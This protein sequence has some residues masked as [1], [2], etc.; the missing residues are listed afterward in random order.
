MVLVKPFLVALCFIFCTYAGSSYSD[1]T[2]KELEDTPSV[3]VLE[4]H[5]DTPKIETKFPGNGYDPNSPKGGVLKFGLVKT[6]F[7]T[8][9]PFIQKDCAPGIGP[10]NSLVFEALM[11][12]DP[13]APFKLHI[14]IAKSVKL[15]RDRSWMEVTLNEDARFNDGSRITANDVIATFNTLAAEGSPSR[16]AFSKKIKT[17]KAIDN[18]KILFIF[19]KTPDSTDKDPKYDLEAPLVTAM[20]PVLS[21][22]DIKSFSFSERGMRPFLGSG[23]YKISKIDPGKSVTFVRN[24]SYWG[25]GKLECIKG[26]YNADT[27]VLKVFYDPSTLFSAFLSG[28][29]HSFQEETA[30]KWNSLQNHPYV[31][32]GKIVLRQVNRNDTVGMTGFAMNTGV[33]PFNDIRFRRAIAGFFDVS[34]LINLLGGDHKPITSFFHGTEFAAKT[35]PDTRETE[36]LKKLSCKN[37]S[38]YELLSRGNKVETKPGDKIGAL[39]Q[40]KECGYELNDNKLIDSKTK[41]PLSIEILINSHDQEKIALC[42]ANQMKQIGVDVFIRLVDG[43][44]YTKR[45]GMHDFQM[46][47]WHWGHSLS[48]GIEQRLYWGSMF[49]DK[50]GRNYSAIRSLD[51]DRVCDMIVSAKT[52]SELVS[53]LRVLDRLLSKGC[54]IIPLSYDT[55]NRYAYWSH[56]GVPHLIDEGREVADVSGFWVKNPQKQNQK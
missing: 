31:K 42:F 8:L 11:E 29:I 49:A 24:K 13:I 47:L 15:A 39:K 22:K 51:I 46:I 38:E 6:P 14:R 44:Q 20:L 26:R 7:C 40:L 27:I 9:N 21:E 18:N 23:P 55:V 17:I 43:A 41:K 30:A 10:Y 12:R 19:N 35:E 33:K 16:Q 1:P 53:L 36:V 50:V 32:Q 34:K 4:M 37:A 3:T 56:V 48:P 54:Y 28:D 52:R 5:Q 25:W 45:I 2:K